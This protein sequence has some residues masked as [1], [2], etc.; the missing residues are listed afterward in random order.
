VKQF[1]EKLVLITGGSSGIGLA[2]AKKLS[3][4]GAHV[5]IL[6]RRPDRNEK[7]MAEIMAE[8]ILPNQSFGSLECD[9]ADQDQLE[10]VLQHFEDM[11]GAPDLLINA[12]GYAY[13]AVFLDIPPA[14][15]KNQ[16]DV[17]F[18]GTVNTIRCLLPGM[19][20]RDSGHII[21]ICSTAGFL[22]GYG[23]SAYSGT[24]YAVR[25][26]TDGLRS[27]LAF[28]G[29]RISINF[30]PDTNTPGFETENLL[31]PD[32]TR[33]ASKAGGL[34]EPE[35]VADSILNGVRKNHYMIVSGLEN[36]FFYFLSNLLGGKMFFVVDFIVAAAAR[37]TQKIK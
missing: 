7:A 25:W 15:M 33:E 24:K 20:A 4:L 17:N 37:K 36:N 1:N 23:Y 10:K 6:A 14:V 16:M 30:P 11:K 22:S 27:E 26:F 21:N 5:W 28:T 35:T 18:F 13:P 12:A 9:I 29:V 19:L 34:A 8:K 3:A 32:I 2:L 31:K